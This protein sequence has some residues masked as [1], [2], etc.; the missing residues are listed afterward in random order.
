MTDDKIETL[1]QQLKAAEEE[2]KNDFK[3]GKMPRGDAYAVID[4][5][6]KELQIARRVKTRE[7]RRTDPKLTRKT[8]I[9]LSED[10]HQALTK[11]AKEVD[12]NIS[13]YIRNLLKEV[14]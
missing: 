6:K 1:E 8:T 7:E 4:K 12:M 10:E 11:K 5:L 2:I 9:M 13:K 3:L 14:L